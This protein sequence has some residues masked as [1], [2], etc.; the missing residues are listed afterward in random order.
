MW[1]DVVEITPDDAYLWG[2]LRTHHSQE[3]LADLQT[4]V[5]SGCEGGWSMEKLADLGERIW[6]MERLFNNAAGFTAKATLRFGL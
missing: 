2:R 5:D 3:S 4:Q 1:L 6:N